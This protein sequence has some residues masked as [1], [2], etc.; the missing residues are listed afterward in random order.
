MNPHQVLLISIY[1]QYFPPQI[2]IIWYFTSVN[3]HVSCQYNFL[4]N[5]V[6]THITIIVY[7]PSMKPPMFCQYTWLCKK[8]VLNTFLLQGISSVLA[9]VCS[10]NIH[11]CVEHFHT[12]QLYGISH[13]NLHMFCH[14]KFMCKLSSHTS[15]LQA[16]SPV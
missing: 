14:Y 15:H 11:L 16:F 7:F 6:S 1:V 5:F 10:V 9:L 12:S 2:T 8:K 13:G 3:P 4:C